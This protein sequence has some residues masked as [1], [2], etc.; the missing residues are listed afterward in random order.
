MSKRP[1]PSVI[2]PRVSFLTVT[3]AP[4]TGVSVSSR[5]TPFTVRLWPLAGGAAAS[6]VTRTATAAKRVLTEFLIVIWLLFV[7][8]FK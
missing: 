6:P 3:N 4:A 8:I 7:I 5:T 2:T 1:A